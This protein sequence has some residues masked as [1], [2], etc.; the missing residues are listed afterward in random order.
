MNEPNELIFPYPARVLRVDAQ[1]RSVE[2]LALAKESRAFD[3]A[4]FD[5]RPPFFWSAEVSNSNVDAYFTFMLPSTL[6]NFA[7]DAKAGI[8]FL[9]SHRHG[10]LP[11]GRSLD[12]Q[13]IDDGG[14]KRV[15]ADF[16]TLPGLNVNGINTTDF[17]DSVRAGV[18]SDVSVGFF[19]GTET[20]QIC[21]RDFWSCPH[22]PGMTYETKGADNIIRQQI[23]TF[24]IDGAH[25]AEVSAVYDGATPDATI[26][27]A[28]RMNEQG[29]L[30][31]EAA[32]VLEARYHRSLF[33]NKRIYKGVDTPERN[34]KT[35]D[36][37]E[38]MVNQIREV[39]TID[40]KT[41]VVGT[42][43][44]TNTELLRLRTLEPEL[45]TLR[46]RVATLEPQA[47]DG[48]Q[49]RNDLVS[50]ALGEGVRAM[51]DKFSKETYETLLRKAPLDVV[52]QMKADWS[53][54]GNARFTG[55]RQSTDEGEQA[56]GTK[57]RTGALI[58]ESA[59]K[60]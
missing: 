16:F 17:I 14:S 55:G 24:A 21:Q 41:D 20:C 11:F 13:M 32:R 43:M 28:Q 22:I 53:A 23:A 38:K 31:P 19:G 52:K 33:D 12:G 51:G 59:Y 8:S 58:P 29:K 44:T 3:P 4:I 56:P 26:L 9:N 15:L 27:K 2:L 48:E 50:E 6:M 60:S 37:F 40:D 25:L 10:E 39:L 42:V 45:V 30:K 1:V 57:K 54:I 18:V 36:E 5:E 46:E 34:T 49:Y 47:K 7:N 35:M